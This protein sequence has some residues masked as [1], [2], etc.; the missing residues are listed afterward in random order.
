MINQ[1]IFAL[2]YNDRYSSGYTHGCSDGRAGGHPYL[3]V[4]PTHTSA[5]MQGYNKGY[6]ACSGK[7]DICSQVKV[8]A[9]AKGLMGAAGIKFDNKLCEDQLK[10]SPSKPIKPKENWWGTCKTIEW[11]LVYSCSTYVRPDGILTQEGNRAKDCISG[12]AFLGG[13]AKLIG[14]IIPTDW[15]LDGLKL[16]A[17]SYH[18]ENIVKWDELKKANAAFEFFGSL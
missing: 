18:C 11:G 3:N 16:L 10:N 4:H 5:F 7:S 2:T 9:A 17:P 13:A 1:S 14:G 8:V 6:T 15:I 12:G